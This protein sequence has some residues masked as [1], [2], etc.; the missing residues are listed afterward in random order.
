VIGG[1][2]PFFVATEARTRM[3]PRATDQ[4]LTGL[5]LWQV[6]AIA[7]AA[8][9]LA[10]S[11]SPLAATGLAAYAIGLVGLITLLPTLRA[12]QFRWAG[13]RLAQ[14]LAGLA[15][16]V[17]VVVAGAIAAARGD[18]PFSGAALVILAVIGYGQ[19]LWASLAYLLPVLRAGG[20]QRLSAG[21]ATMRSWPALVAA[22]LAGV[23]LVL[24][25]APVAA[26]LVGAWV[27]DAAWRIVRLELED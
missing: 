25:A 1:T 2:M 9:G 5:L 26:V 10:W 22:N 12:K 6:A 13:P 11:R 23:A 18:A 19:V 24:G 3:S 21:F 8:G 27:V 7:L 4:R 20:Y 17:G 15:W 14:L 16:W